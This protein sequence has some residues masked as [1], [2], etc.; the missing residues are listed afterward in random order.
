MKIRSA[1]STLSLSAALHTPPVTEHIQHLILPKHVLNTLHAESMS[2]N[3]INDSG[4]FIN[5][6]PQSIDVPFQLPVL[7]VE[8]MLETRPEGNPVF[9]QLPMK[10]EAPSFR[11]G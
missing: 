3:A 4:L 10:L 1:A 8:A 2:A 5:D 11:A 6:R 9:V 7:L